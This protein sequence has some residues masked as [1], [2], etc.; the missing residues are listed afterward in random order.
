MDVLRWEDGRVDSALRRPRV[1]G[2]RYG[3]RGFVQTWFLA[4]LALLIVAPV[5]QAQAVDSA[6]ATAHDSTAESAPLLCYT[7][8]TPGTADMIIPGTPA[9]PAMGDVPGTPGIPSMV[10]PGTPPTPDLWYVCR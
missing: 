5:A 10:I 9:T 6:A 8:G 7:P 2:D 3:T 4:S 1:E